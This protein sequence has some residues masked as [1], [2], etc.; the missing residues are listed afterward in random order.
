MCVFRMTLAEMAVYGL[1]QETDRQSALERVLVFIDSVWEGG[2]VTGYRHLFS[3]GNRI[4]VI[5]TNGGVMEGVR[6][7]CTGIC[8]GWAAA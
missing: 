4:S 6:V 5:I 1:N 7:V 2:C 8:W 3:G